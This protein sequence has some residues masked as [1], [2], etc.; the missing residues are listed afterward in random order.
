[1]TKVSRRTFISLAQDVGALPHV[2]KQV[3]HAPATDVFTAYTTLR[4]ETFC[5]EV[6]K[7]RVELATGLLPEPGADAQPVAV[8]TELLVGRLGLE[9]R[10]GGLG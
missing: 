10:T 9:A 6:A 4:W 7:L 5:R 1:L 2:L 3:T 8:P